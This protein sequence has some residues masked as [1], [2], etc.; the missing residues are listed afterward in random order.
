MRA[1]TDGVTHDRHDPRP[2]RNAMR[3]R[4][5]SERLAYPASAALRA[6]ALV[7][8]LGHE[9]RLGHGRP[10]TTFCSFAPDLR[11]QVSELRDDLGVRRQLVIADAAIAQLLTHVH[12]QLEPTQAQTR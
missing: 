2:G 10:V 8:Y 3:V 6:V 5:L 1:V 11:P 9:L 4:V 7:E 12:R